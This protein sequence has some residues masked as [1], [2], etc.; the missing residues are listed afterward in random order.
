MSHLF[1]GSDG[2]GSL[3]CWMR[4]MAYLSYTDNPFM[5]GVLFKRAIPIYLKI[6][7]NLAILLTAFVAFSRVVYETSTKFENIQLGYYEYLFNYFQY[8]IFENFKAL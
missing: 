7:S 5:L 3:F 6:L 2:L 4:L 1:G 8:G